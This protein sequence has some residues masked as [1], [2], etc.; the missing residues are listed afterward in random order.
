MDKEAVVNYFKPLL[1]AFLGK[2]SAPKLPTE[3]EQ[4]TIYPL[5]TILSDL[6]EIQQDDWAEYAFSR[7][8]VN[9]K[10]SSE[11]RLEFFQTAYECGKTA[12][13]EY[14]EKYQTEDP[15]KLAKKLKL[16]LEYPLIPQNADRVLFAEFVE[17]NHI[18][19]YMDGVRKAKKRIQQESLEY[20]LPEDFDISAVLL[21]HELF[22]VV[23]DEKKDD[24]WTST[25]K[26]E[27]RKDKWFKNKIRLVVLSEIAAMGFAQEMTQIPFSPYVLDAFLVYGYSPKAASA[28]YEEMMIFVG[29]DPTKT[30]TKTICEVE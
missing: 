18:Y 24:I 22:H 15:R 6:M 20:L 13:Q 21:S 5:H 19:V 12:A 11:Q 17:P 2:P 14:K 23:E 29:K 7:D 9:G 26:I 1:R 28:L 27:L 25:F 16:I 4:L 10:L 30:D 3:M 8:P